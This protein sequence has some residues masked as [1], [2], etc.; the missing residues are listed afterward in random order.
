MVS[1]SEKVDIIIYG[2]RNQ[3]STEVARV[4]VNCYP[5]R[6]NILLRLTKNLQ[7]HKFFQMD[8]FPDNKKLN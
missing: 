5:G 1:N 2:K 7:T 3:H 6:Y 4:C 8:I